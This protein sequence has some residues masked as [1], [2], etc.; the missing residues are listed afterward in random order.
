MV[1]V[2]DRMPVILAREDWDTWTQADPA[3][4]LAL[5]R[6]CDLE[7]LVERTQERWAGGGKDGTVQGGLL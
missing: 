6:K 3:V 4:A 1:E 7:L 5:A 2:H